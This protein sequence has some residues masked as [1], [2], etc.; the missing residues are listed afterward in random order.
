VHPTEQQY[1]GGKGDEEQTEDTERD[2]PVSTFLDKV[3]A[4]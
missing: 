4:E 2:C 3:S 1:R